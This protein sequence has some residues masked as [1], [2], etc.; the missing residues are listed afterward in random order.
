M[1]HLIIVIFLLCGIGF[2]QAAEMVVGARELNKAALSA[3]PGDVI[4]IAA[5]RY[6]DVELKISARGTEEKPILIEADGGGKVTLCGASNLR[7]AG[8]WVVIRG[9][10]FEDGHSPDGAVIEYR[11]GDEVANNCRITGC[12]VTNYNPPKRNLDYSYVSMYD[13]TR[14]DQTEDFAVEYVGGES[15]RLYAWFCSF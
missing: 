7:L 4:R 12:A 3:H 8:E 1:K 15:Y 6:S 9:L 11:L 10:H 14:I 5:G 13:I 2:A